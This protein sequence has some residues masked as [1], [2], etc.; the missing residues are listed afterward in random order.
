GTSSVS[1]PSVSSSSSSSSLSSSSL[2]SSSLSSSS[3]SSSAASTSSASTSS[4][5]EDMISAA[6]PAVVLVETSNGRGSAFFVSRDTLI[7][8]VHVVGSNGSVTIQRVNGVKESALVADLSREFDI[9]VLRV[10]D[11]DPTQ[12]TIALG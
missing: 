3:L 11:P 1:S 8:N 6:I 4:L 7:T 2:S 9:A 10:S 5:L 12:A